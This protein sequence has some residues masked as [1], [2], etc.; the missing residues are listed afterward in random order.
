MQE[1]NEILRQENEALKKRLF[2]FSHQLGNNEKSTTPIFQ[3]DVRS[4]ELYIFT[5]REK[6]LNEPLR[7]SLNSC[8]ESLE[9]LKIK[10]EIQT[11]ETQRWR[12]RAHQLIEKTFVSKAKMLFWKIL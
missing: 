9:S 7:V 3:P 12:E 8:R 5:E 11:S 6:E 2:D 1:N 4:I 10:M